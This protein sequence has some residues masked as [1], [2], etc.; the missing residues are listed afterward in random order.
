[1]SSCLN[2][3]NEE[4]LSHHGSPVCP[5]VGRPMADCY[6]R[7]MMSSNI[8]LVI[9]YCRDQYDSCPVYRGEDTDRSREVEP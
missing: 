7:N 6:C 2:P 5:H 3:P 4:F 9:Y 8:P 1:M